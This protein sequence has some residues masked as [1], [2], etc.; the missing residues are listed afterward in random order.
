MEVAVQKLGVGGFTP[1]PPLGGREL[2]E[3][4]VVSWSVKSHSVMNT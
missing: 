2:I 3:K 1:P 4:E